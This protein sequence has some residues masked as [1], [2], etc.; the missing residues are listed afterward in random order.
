MNLRLGLRS[1]ADPGKQP[2]KG[3]WDLC[4]FRA[5]A[6]DLVIILWNISSAGWGCWF[7]LLARCNGSHGGQSISGNEVPIGARAG[8]CEHTQP[9]RRNTNTLQQKS[10]K[11][12][13][14][15][16][17]LG[18][19]FNSHYSSQ[20]KSHLCVTDVPEQQ[21]AN[22]GQAHRHCLNNLSCCLH[23]ESGHWGRWSQ[24]PG[25]SF[26]CPNS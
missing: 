13:M 1:S 24:Q 6:F 18:Y 16:T 9:G 7:N 3:S 17:L 5:P 26:P 10:S 25:Y 2:V 14:M 4:G 11:Q 23:S 22:R 20:N 8:I 12:A 19:C 21:A 15:C